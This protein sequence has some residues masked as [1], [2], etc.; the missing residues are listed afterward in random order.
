M[1][2]IPILSQPVATSHVPSALQRDA[3]MSGSVT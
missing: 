3:E 2:R 1:E